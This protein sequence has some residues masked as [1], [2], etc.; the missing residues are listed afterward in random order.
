MNADL[1]MN[2]VENVMMKEKI[3][4]HNVKMVIFSL[5]IDVFITVQQDIS[6]M[7]II[8]ANYVIQIVKLVKNQLKIVYHVTTDI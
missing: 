3:N 2:L 7:E 8:N 6:W 1:A 4:A 5:K